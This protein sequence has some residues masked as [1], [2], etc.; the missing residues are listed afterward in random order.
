MA[1]AAIALHNKLTG[2][3]LLRGPARHLTYL[4]VMRGPLWHVAEPLLK[5][6]FKGVFRL[7]LATKILQISNNG[8]P[9]PFRVTCNVLMGPLVSPDTVLKS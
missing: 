9:N 4:V 8:H 3:V 5:I 2:Q 6:P 1:T 7:N